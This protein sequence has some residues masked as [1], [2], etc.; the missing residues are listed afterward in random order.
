MNFCPCLHPRASFWG[1]AVLFFLI[2][3]LCFIGVQFANIQNNTQCS[4]HQVPPSVPITHHPHPLPTSPST[5]PR[6]FPRVRSLSCSVSL[7]DISHSVFLLSPLFPFT[8]FLYSPNEWDHIMF[9]LLRLTYFTQHN[10]LQFHPRWSKWGVFV[11]SKG[12]GIFHCI[13]KPH[14]LY[15]FFF[16]WTPRLLPQFGYCGHCC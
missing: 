7:S 5:T 3:N 12:W 1:F 11:I 10:T 13:H 6:S 15:P 9:V 2:I 8:I 16:R 14:L 4:S